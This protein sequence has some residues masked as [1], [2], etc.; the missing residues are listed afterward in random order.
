MS[1]CY[2]SAVLKVAEGEIGYLEKASNSQLDEIRTTPS[3]PVTS[4]RSTPLGTTARRMA[5]LGAI[6]SWTGVC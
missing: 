1:K 6:C 5:S 3:M 4:T 2:A